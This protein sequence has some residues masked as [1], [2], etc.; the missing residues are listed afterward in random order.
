MVHERSCAA[1]VCCLGGFTIAGVSMEGGQG[2]FG[3]VV[4]FA[5]VVLLLTLLNWRD[6][7][8]M[9][10]RYAVLDQLALPELRGRVGIHIRCAL[11]S[12]RSTVV[13]D[14]LAGTPNEVWN[15][16]TRVASRLPPHTRL[17]VQSTLDRAGVR[18]FTLETTTGQL[19]SHASHTLLVSR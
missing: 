7:R 14:L 10:L 11:I 6:R 19:P 8:A 13:V 1:L 12:R 4:T 15:V 3:V 9:R 2:V 18:P 17:V 16:C 5:A